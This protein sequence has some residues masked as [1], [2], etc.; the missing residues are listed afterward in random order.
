MWRS[1]GITQS[2]VTDFLFLHLLLSVQAPLMN[3]YNI[4]IIIIIFVI[5]IT[6]SSWPQDWSHA[7]NASWSQWF[8]PFSQLITDNRKEHDHLFDYSNNRV[9]MKEW[10]RCSSK[11]AISSS[12]C[13]WVLR[14]PLLKDNSSLTSKASSWEVIQGRRSLKYTRLPLDFDLSILIDCN[15]L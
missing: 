3:L 13:Y 15:E 6:P 1:L 11:D 8:F 12:I 14:P 9:I 4:I 5:I 10:W 7:E 2:R